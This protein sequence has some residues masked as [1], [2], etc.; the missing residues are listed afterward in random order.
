ML[1]S[2]ADKS[3]SLKTTIWVLV[4]LSGHSPLNVIVPPKPGGSATIGFG[5]IP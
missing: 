2:D 3:G 4:M 1:K 5:S